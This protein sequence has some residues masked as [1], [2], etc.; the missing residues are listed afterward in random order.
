MLFRIKYVYILLPS[1]FVDAR[2]SNSCAVSFVK[3]CYIVASDSIVL[4]VKDIDVISM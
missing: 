1:I 2:A 4:L 3:Y